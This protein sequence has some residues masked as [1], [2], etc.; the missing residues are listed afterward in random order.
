MDCGRPTGVALYYQLHGQQLA[1]R[2]GAIGVSGGGGIGV[3]GVG[4]SMELN[5][6]RCGKNTP[7]GTSAA[8]G[9]FVTCTP[10]VGGASALAKLDAI[11]VTKP[12]PM[13][14]SPCL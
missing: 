2:A 3:F 14:S 4:A 7:A 11:T 10:A 13:T 1:Q 6:P 9:P 12:R 5:A 8:S